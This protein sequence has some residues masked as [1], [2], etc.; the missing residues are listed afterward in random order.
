[1]AKGLA[2]LGLL[3]IVGIAVVGCDTT[4]DG[5]DPDDTTNEP[6]FAGNIVVE[7]CVI[8]FGIKLPGETGSRNVVVKN[9]GAGPLGLLSVEVGSPFSVQT[10]T[11]LNVEAGRTYQFA[12][13][14]QPTAGDFGTFSEDLIIQSDDPQEPSIVCVATAK[15]T[16]D[17]DLDGFTTIDAGGT[18]CDD[19]NPD[20]NPGADEIW[21]D[22]VDQDCDGASDYDQDRDGFDSK[23]FWASPT[24]DNP[25]TGQKG[26]DCQDVDDSMNPGQVEVWYDGKD[27]DC[28]GWNDFDRDRDGFR[29]AEF[30]YDDCND[31]DPLANPHAIEAFNGADDDCNGLVDDKAS[32]ERADRIGYGYDEEEAGAGRGIAIADFDSNGKAEIAIGVHYALYAKTGDTTGNAQGG[33][34]IFFDGGLADSDY[35]GDNS[36]EDIWIAGA[37]ATD[38]LG[39]E[40][41]SVPDFDGD[42]VPDLI[43]NAIGY[44]GWKGRTYVFSGADLQTTTTISDADLS[45]TGLTDYMLG[46]GLGTGDMNGDGL[47]DLVLFGG[48]RA[49]HFTFMAV[50]YGSTSSLGD[51]DWTEIDATFTQICGV[52][53]ASTYYPTTCGPSFYYTTAGDPGAAD[54]YYG[55]GHTNADF[56]ADG[57]DDQLH[58]D[59]WSDDGGKTD[60]GAAWILWGRRSEYTNSNSFYKDTQTMIAAG[61]TDKAH[62][63]ISVAVMPDVDGDGADE[64]AI[65]DD[66]NS[67]LYVL[68]GDTDLRT[69]LRDLE[70]ESGF[71]L[72]G[73]SAFSSGFNAGDWTGD[74]VD[75]MALAFGGAAAGGKGGGLYLFES[76][77]LYG[78]HRA[79]AVVYG[80]I[81]GDVFNAS[82]GMGAPISTG[83]LDGNTTSDLVVGDWQYD[84]TDLGDEGPEG[85]V[86]VFFNQNL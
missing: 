76:R 43:M 80:S 22:G 30:G 10:N 54:E 16:D 78:V 36:D 86:F 73:M 66:S 20:I 68:Y 84:N 27:A 15:V 25:A 37:S 35:I 51:L 77:A 31:D 74:G 3:G 34:A 24:D 49:D 23:V 28:D 41:I 52:D 21:Y 1:V 40:V 82:F 14:F 47:S 70:E 64:V 44:G 69:G 72:R 39:F 65:L 48:A 45:L 55:N 29:T 13:R 12:L 11:P 6:D 26:G 62:L 53:G 8:D 58:G 75:D 42:G 50:Q 18:D 63:G 67:S 60:G 2:K 9:T 32:P 19:S 83:D 59:K 85:A 38:E 81:V 61:S 79:D 7:P 17:A 5:P 4:T 56:D 57:Y 33:V 71:I 46:G